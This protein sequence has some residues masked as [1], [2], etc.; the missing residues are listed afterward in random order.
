MGQVRVIGS[1][2][3]PLLASK[4]AGEAKDASMSVHQPT[5]KAVPGV[6]VGAKPDVAAPFGLFDSG[7]DGRAVIL[8]C[9]PRCVHS[10]R[11]S[12]TTFVFSFY[13]LLHKFI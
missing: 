10:L 13:S 7:V 5:L 3:A 11:H 6:V 12:V 8:K 4:S 2:G 1:G 9:F